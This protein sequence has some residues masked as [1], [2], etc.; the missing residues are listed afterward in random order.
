MAHS[1]LLPGFND[2]VDD[3]QRVFR[4]TLAAL[5]RPARPTGLPAT[6]CEAPAPLMPTAA[7][8]L[9]ALV[10]YE[11]PLWL[12]TAADRPEVR[13][14][15]RFHCGCTLAARPDEAA[16]ALIAD[17]A[18][19]PPLSSFA[20]GSHEYPDRSTTLVIQVPG[21][22]EGTGWRFAGPG[23][24]GTSSIEIG[25]LPAAFREQLAANHAGFPLGVD[26]LFVCGNRIA[27]LPRS[28]RLED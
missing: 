9:L 23:I 4:A 17:A 7:S 2:P 22:T 13:E 27:G 11:T 6:L 3:A 10:D 14:F 15:L 18:A 26:L 19:M 16:F 25:G 8:V 1:N 24:H 12:D 28:S 20:H 21:L 5:S